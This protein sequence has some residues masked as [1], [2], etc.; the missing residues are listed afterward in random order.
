MLIQGFAKS[1]GA[2][3]VSLS[4]FWAPLLDIVRHADIIASG[5]CLG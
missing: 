1:L 4:G 2:R 5:S 3:E